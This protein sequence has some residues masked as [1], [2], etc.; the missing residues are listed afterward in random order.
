[1][2]RQDGLVLN[3]PRKFPTKKEQ[4]NKNTNKS[5][6]F[7]GTIQKQRNRAKQQ[8]NTPI[9]YSNLRTGITGF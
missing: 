3:T 7:L 2:E 9:K 5:I 6:E 8:S 4:D 1:M